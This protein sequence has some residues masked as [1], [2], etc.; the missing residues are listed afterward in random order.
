MRQPMGGS[1]GGGGDGGL[2]GGDGG[3]GIGDGGGGRTG[4]V[5]GGEI[6]KGGRD[7]GDGGGDGGDGSWGGGGGV[8]GSKG[9]IRPRSHMSQ[10]SARV[11]SGRDAFMVNKRDSHDMHLSPTCQGGTLTAGT[12]SSSHLGPSNSLGAARR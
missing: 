12:Q 9:A 8:G 6:G 4:G 5:G 7:G 11:Q 1:D 3:V 10:C 2:R